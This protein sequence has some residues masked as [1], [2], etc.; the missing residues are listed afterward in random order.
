[1]K[2]ISYKQRIR[3]LARLPN[4][5]LIQVLKSTVAR[6]HGLEIE[7]DELELA[8]DDDQKEIEEY[9]YEIDKCHERMKDIDEFTRAVQANEILTILNA[10]S[11]LAHMADERKEEQNGIKKLE[12]A[13]GWHEQQFQKLQGQCTMLKKERAKLQK[14]CIE[15][16]SILRRSGVSEVLRARLAKLN[17]RSV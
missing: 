8:L 9:T 5:A 16:C 10:A 11:V 15:I 3:C 6:L 14:I 1:M 12:E 13:R 17:F 7:L 4:F 2:M